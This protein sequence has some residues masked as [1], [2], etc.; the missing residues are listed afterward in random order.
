MSPNLLRATQLALETNATEA[1]AKLEML[2]N[3]PTAVIDHMDILDEIVKQTKILSQSEAA[4]RT[5]QH[6][7]IHIPKAREAAQQKAETP[8]ENE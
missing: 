4:L 2:L 1:L 6:Y 7:F 8:N 5:F 3:N